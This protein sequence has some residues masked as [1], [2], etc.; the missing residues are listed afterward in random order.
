MPCNPKPERRKWKRGYIR[1]RAI[2]AEKVKRLKVGAT[3]LACSPGGDRG[4]VLK[5]EGPY[6]APYMSYGRYFQEYDLLMGFEDGRI[7]WHGLHDCCDLDPSTEPGDF[8]KAQRYYQMSEDGLSWEE[9]MD[10]I[11]KEE[12]NVA[13]D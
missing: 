9:I 5:I 1:E 8:S 4:I 13:Q 3:Y 10:I 11:I 7:S 6:K 2:H 12:E